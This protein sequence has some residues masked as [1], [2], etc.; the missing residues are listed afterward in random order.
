MLQNVA[1]FLIGIG[2]L[3]LIGWGVKDFFME[4]EIP[5]L[6]RVAVGAVGAGIVILLGIALKD[7]MTKARTDKFKGVDR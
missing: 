2:V 6:I 5:L 3:V 7:R 4:S 1:F